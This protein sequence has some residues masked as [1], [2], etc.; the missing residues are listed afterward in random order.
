MCVALFRSQQRS[1]QR[2]RLIDIHVFVAN[3][4][5]IICINHINTQLPYIIHTFKWM[6]KNG[7][8]RFSL[9]RMCVHCEGQGREWSGKRIDGLN[10]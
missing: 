3:K 6:Y 7:L 10:N 2:I 4:Q 8:K 9:D 1:T 5:S